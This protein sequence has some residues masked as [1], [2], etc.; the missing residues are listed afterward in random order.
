MKGWQHCQ[1]GKEATVVD[2]LKVRRTGIADHEKM[3]NE[4]QSQENVQKEDPRK[5]GRTS[6]PKQQAT[7][8]KIR[9]ARLC[10][11]EQL[12]RKIVEIGQSFFVAVKDD[13]RQAHVDRNLDRLPDQLLHA[14]S[15]MGQR[16][17]F[18][19]CG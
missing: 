6:P 5:V 4:I 9:P 7:D 17:E 19:R 8:N 11:S 15:V 2:G 10:S 3:A 1:D 14:R 18:L 12:E 13:R 16:P